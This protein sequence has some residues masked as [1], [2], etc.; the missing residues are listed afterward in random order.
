MDHTKQDR[1]WTV[2]RGRDLLF[3][4][5]V[6]LLNDGCLRVVLDRT[7]TYWASEN[8]WGIGPKKRI[9][10]GSPGLLSRSK[11]QNFSLCESERA[12]RDPG[13]CHVNETAL[14][15]PTWSSYS[16]PSG[17][18]KNQCILS[19]VEESESEGKKV[20]ERISIRLIRLRLR[21]H[22]TYFFATEPDCTYTFFKIT[23]R[24]SH[25]LLVKESLC[26]CLLLWLAL[27]IDQ[28]KTSLVQHGK[29]NWEESAKKRKRVNILMCIWEIVLG[30][31][32][33]QAVGS[34]LLVPNLGQW[35]KARSIDQYRVSVLSIA[36]AAS[37]SSIWSFILD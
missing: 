3:D 11:R 28:P 9:K 2:L 27:L 33:V 35:A 32:S 6:D 31:R 4:L 12:N 5:P 30:L 1:N 34:W 13:S 26:L 21:S 14:R 36:V 29:F 22:S 10:D 24:K 17:K 18:A 19:Q 25:R 8:H 16:L 23:G 7:T 20:D 15:S 37:A